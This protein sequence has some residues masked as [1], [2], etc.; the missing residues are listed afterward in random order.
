M[1]KQELTYESALSM[2]TEFLLDKHK[3]NTQDVAGILLASEDE[4][5]KIALWL[6]QHAKFLLV[7]AEKI[8]E[9]GKE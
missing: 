3:S 9:G 2:A 4:P 7:V 8:E 5:K 1:D 6:R